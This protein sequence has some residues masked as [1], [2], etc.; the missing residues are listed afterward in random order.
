MSSHLFCRLR[1]KKVAATPEEHVRQRLI[2]Y[3]IDHLGF[4]LHTLVVEK[5]LHQL[6]HLDPS[7]C[8]SLERRFDL[9][10]LEADF[11]PHHPLFPLLLVECKAVKLGAKERRQL[12]GYNHYL[13]APFI[14]L[15]NQ[16]EIMTGH[17]DR[18]VGGYQFEPRLPSRD[19]LLIR[20]KST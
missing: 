8:R 3:M 14:C 4:P 1:Q 11:H 16:D 19:E 2:G 10:T 18:V 15:V 17:Y 5:G 20:A 7:I 6:P 9:I 12:E 13:Q